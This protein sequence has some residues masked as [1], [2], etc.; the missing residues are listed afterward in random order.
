M[1]AKI[2][3]LVLNAWDAFMDYV[4]DIYGDSYFEIA[5]KEQVKFEWEEFSRNLTV[6][7]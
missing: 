3:T 1:K 4:N 5:S 6:N 7:N 2:D